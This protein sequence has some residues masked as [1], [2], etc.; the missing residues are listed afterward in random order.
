MTCQLTLK[1]KVNG[2]CHQVKKN[3]VFGTL[4]S[5][6]SYQKGEGYGM[7]AK[8]HKGHGQVRVPNKGRWAHIN[9][10]LLHLFIFHKN[11]WPYISVE[12]FRLYCF[13]FLSN[14]A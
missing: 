4:Q 5:L 7:K 3:V 10:K 14:D 9:V 6:N 11:A 8:G 13:P 2:Q 1:V 12:H